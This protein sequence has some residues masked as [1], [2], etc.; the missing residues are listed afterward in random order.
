V[1]E[2]VADTA[3][4][5]GAKQILLPSPFLKVPGQCPLSLSVIVKVERERE[6]EREWHFGKRKGKVLRRDFISNRGMKLSSG[7]T[8]YD[9]F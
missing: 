4:V 2:V 9:F 3:F 1:A 6:R 5:V 8:E 7:F